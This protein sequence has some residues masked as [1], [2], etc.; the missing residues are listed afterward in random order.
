MMPQFQVFLIC[1]SL[2]FCGGALYDVFYLLA[3]PF[4]KY[5]PVQIIRDILFCIAFA[6]GYVFLSL[7]LRL[8]PIRFYL[9]LGLVLGFILWL[10]SLHKTLAFIENKVYNTFEANLRKRG[11]TRKCRLSLKKRKSAS[12]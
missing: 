9:I 1:A 11:K 2:G 3:F 8:P 6:G 12:R 4:K 10:E 5:R 7:C